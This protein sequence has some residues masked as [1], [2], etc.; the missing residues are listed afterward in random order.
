LVDE[1]FDGS[2]GDMLKSHQIS[3]VQQSTCCLT[4]AFQ[5]A[6]QG[7]PMR[8]L[9]LPFICVL[10]IAVL[11]GQT[12]SPIKNPPPDERFKT[13]ILLVV[14][15]PDD[16]TLVASYLAKAVYDEHRRVSVLY[17][18]RGDAGP[19]H[20]G[21]EQAGALGAVRE[22]EARR[23]LASLNI[24]NVWFLEG[25]DTASQDVLQSLERWGHGGALEQTV[26]VMR[27][28]RPEIVLTW[29]P[30]VVAGENHG[31]HQAA[32][33]IATEAFDVAADPTVFPEQVAVPR[34]H[35]AINNLTE[36][37]QPWQPKKLYYFSDAYDTTF[38]DTFGPRYALTDVSPAQGTSYAVLAARE[39]RHYSS[40]LG[41]PELR[42]ALARG[43]EKAVVRLLTGGDEPLLPNPLRLVLGK[44]HVHANA[45]ADVFEGITPGRVIAAERSRAAPTPA[46]RAS[47]MLG[48][49]WAFYER[50]WRRHDIEH[51]AR[52]GPPMIAIAPGAVLRVPM[53]LVNETGQPKEIRVRPASMPE[54]WSE[55][56]GSGVYAVAA[57]EIVAADV[58]LQSP[59]RNSREVTV[60]S[61]T[62]DSGGQPL[63][64]VALRV[65]LH[66]GGLPQ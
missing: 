43:D 13:D 49:P 42:D 14:A 60:I 30:R 29:L 21:H 20:V 4:R 17:G 56:S 37:L 41:Y 1:T 35:A 26:R 51:L 61:Y 7:L 58:L 5:R 22:I 11:D 48:D 33:V 64:S 18:T 15:H 12:P 50:F 65:Q 66:Q 46:E 2:R 54:G 36:G 10:G 24:L 34:N 28:A 57:G 53:L 52:L 6:S 19:N 45:T 23:A 40:Q 27:L 55:R 62:A 25:R 39:A 38:I 31:D 32:G 44:S 8:K 3:A 63:G 16:D 47:L 9:I 59:A